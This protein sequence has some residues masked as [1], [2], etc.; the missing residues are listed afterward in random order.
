MALTKKV[1]EMLEQMNIKD[2]GDKAKELK[3]AEELADKYDDIRPKTYA[4]PMERVCG[5]PIYDKQPQSINTQ[6]HIL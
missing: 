5:L 1:E 4:V 6:A 2:H 3:K